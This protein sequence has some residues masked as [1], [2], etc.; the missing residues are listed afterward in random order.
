MYVRLEGSFCKIFFNVTASSFI[1]AHEI[2]RPLLYTK[3]GWVL[4]PPN[5]AKLITFN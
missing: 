5:E 4:K 1:N 3:E 2:Q